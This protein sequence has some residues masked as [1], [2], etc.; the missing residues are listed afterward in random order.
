MLLMIKIDCQEQKSPLSV[1]KLT[2]EWMFFIKKK[3]T[4]FICCDTFLPA[5]E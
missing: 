2:G 5:P 1:L 3:V 4:V